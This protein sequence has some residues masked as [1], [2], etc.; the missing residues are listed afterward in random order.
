MW[1]EMSD[2]YYR[3][4]QWLRTK[5]ERTHYDSGRAFQRWALD[6][7]GVSPTWRILDGGCG[8]GRFIWS[9]I[10]DDRVPAEQIVGVDQSPGMLRATRAE[11]M[12]RDK[13]V[14]F[15]VASLE[16]LP[17]PEHTFDLVIAAHVLYHLSN[18]ECGVQE[19]AR[20]VKLQGRVLVTTNSNAINPLVL[21]LHQQALRVL[22]LTQ[23]VEDASP[24]S[25]ENGA[26]V[27]QRAFA[28]VAT[29]R[30]EDTLTFPDVDTF[31]QLYTSI[32]RYR[33]LLSDEALA[34]EIRTRLAPEVRQLAQAL[35][36]QQG[37]LRSRVLMAAFVCEEPVRQRE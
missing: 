26:E 2:A 30:F 25:L 21:D 9:L 16:R 10:D 23:P 12:R 3:D 33:S 37:I 27:L 18:L 17:F 13:S 6:L 24:F 11:A 22:G 15:S 32:G 36:E 8:W 31:M 34:L 5:H 35:I 20:T 29:Y 28:R 19:L 1:R 7:V 4:G 14:G